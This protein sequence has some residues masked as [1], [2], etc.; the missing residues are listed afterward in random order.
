MSLLGREGLKEVARLCLHKAEYARQKIESIK[1]VLV[2]RS[3]PTF[4]EFVVKLPKDPNEII[5]KLMEHNIAAG[6][7]LRRYYNDMS[8]YMLVAVTEKRTK[9]EIAMYAEALEEALWN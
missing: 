8:E 5:G 9:Q 1:G 7:P 4:N 6:F 2:M 3:T